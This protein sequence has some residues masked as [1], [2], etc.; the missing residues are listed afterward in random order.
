MALFSPKKHFH[1]IYDITPEYLHT[2]GVRALV[3]DIDNTLV[4]YQT[5]RPTDNVV[6]WINLMRSHG[7]GV[8]IASNNNRARVEEFCRGLDVFFTYKSGKPGS[9]CIKL[10]CKRWGILPREVAVVGDQI[11]TDV[12]C[13]NLGGAVS[14]LVDSLGG[15]EN[16]FIKFKRLL[17]KP[18]IR[19]YKKHHPDEF[20]EDKNEA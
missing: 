10:S 18:I 4:T 9:K 16:A 7:V 2:V 13:A 5:P 19:S 20:S 1:S 3:L 14:Y 12:L 17:E 6:E 15:R 11:F 8:T